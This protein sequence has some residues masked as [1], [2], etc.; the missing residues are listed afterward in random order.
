MF[1]YFYDNV[2]RIFIDLKYKIPYFD[3]L[4]VTIFLF[5]NLFCVLRDDQIV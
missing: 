1:E 3:F 4:S 2:H 5:V